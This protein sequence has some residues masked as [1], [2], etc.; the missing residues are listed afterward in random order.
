MKRWLSK[1][2][3]PL[4]A[5]LAVMMALSVLQAGGFFQP[6]YASSDLAGESD[7]SEDDSAFDVEAD[8]DVTDDTTGSDDEVS[9]GNVTEA[10]T[11]TEEGAE[12][13]TETG[14]ETGSDEKVPEDGIVPGNEN[15]D[16]SANDEVTVPCVLDIEGLTVSAVVSSDAEVPADVCLSVSKLEPD[17]EAAVEA[18]VRDKLEFGGSD[19][20]YLLS[21]DVS[22][23][24]G[25]ERV[26]PAA[27]SVELTLVF[28][29]V[30]FA[31]VSTQEARPFVFHVCA[32]GSVEKIEPEWVSETELKFSVESFSVMGLALVVPEVSDDD[33]S[34]GDSEPETDT[35]PDDGEN[36]PEDEVSG[37]DAELGD[38]PVGD[39]EPEYDTMPAADLPSVEFEDL[40]SNTLLYAGTSV[41]INEYVIVEPVQVEYEPYGL[42]DVKLRIRNVFDGSWRLVP[43]GDFWDDT[44][45]TPQ[46]TDVE[47]GPYY[48]DIEAYIP[49][50]DGGPDVDVR[51]D[52]HRVMN[53][54]IV[55][56]G[57]V[58]PELDADEAY[59]S[60]VGFGNSMHQVQE[61]LDGTSSWD[62][63][64]QPGNDSGDNNRIVRTF[65]TIQYNTYI[66]TA[67][68]GDSLAGG[69]ESGVVC[70]EYVLHDVT[71]QEVDFDT[72]QWL[73][74][75]DV[76]SFVSEI[77]SDVVLRGSFVLSGEGGQSFVGE[78]EVVI[79][80]FVKVFN[81]QNGDKI[82]FSCSYWM[83]HNDIGVELITSTYGDS[84]PHVDYNSPLVSSLSRECVRHK[85]MELC[86]ATA[87]TVTVSARPSFN[88]QV[89]PVPVN[90]AAYVGSFDFSGSV[91]DVPNLNIGTVP[92]GRLYG[93]GVTLMM[94]NL[95]EDDN[96]G[97][98][99]LEL[100]QPGS[101]ITFDLHT[102]SSFKGVDGRD[103]KTGDADY[104]WDPLYWIIGSNEDS[105]DVLYEPVSRSVPDYIL[106]EAVKA[107][108]YNSSYYSDGIKNDEYTDGG[109]WR[110]EQDPDDPTTVHVTVSGFRPYRSVFDDFFTYEDLD[111][112]QVWSESVLYKEVYPFSAGRIWLVQP[113]V[114]LSGTDMIY[115]ADTGVESISV[116]TNLYDDNFKYNEPGKAEIS[117]Q[118]KLDDDMATQAEV[119]RRPGKISDFI[120]Y[121]F[122]KRIESTWS[123][124]VVQEPGSD[125]VWAVG[126]GGY[127][128]SGD[129]DV[130]RG[131]NKSWA[132][133]GKTIGI[134]S[135]IEYTGADGRN[136]A[137]AYDH[138]MKW[139]SNFFDP[140]VLY[141]CGCDTPFVVR[142]CA[143]ADTDDGSWNG[144]AGEKNPDAAG[145]DDAMRNATPE[146]MLMYDSLDA[147][148][149]AGKVCVGVYME[150]RGVSYVSIKFPLVGGYVCQG[151]DGVY[152]TC[153]TN[154][155]WRMYDIENEA[156][157]YIGKPT[158]QLT[159]VDFN[160]YLQ[161]ASGGFPSRGN[162]VASTKS[163]SEYPSRFWEDSA[164]DAEK[165][166]GHSVDS[167][168]SKQYKKADYS[169][170]ASS[171]EYDYGHYMRY[172]GDCCLVV[173]VV[174]SV[175]LEKVWDSY[176]SQLNLSDG[177]RYVTFCANPYLVFNKPIDIGGHA[178]DV[179]NVTV[180]FALG[181]GSD[182]G[183]RFFQYVP[184]TMCVRNGDMYVSD[185]SSHLRPIEIPGSE[186][187]EVQITEDGKLRVTFDKV[188]VRIDGTYELPKIYFTLLVGTPGVIEMDVAE[189]GEEEARI[190]CS[191]GCDEDSK[192]ENREDGAWVTA[193]RRSSDGLYKS[194]ETLVVEDDEE[195]VFTMRVSNTNTMMLH[196][197]LVVDV[198]PY[199][200]EGSLSNFTGQTVITS[201]SAGGYDGTAGGENSYE[202]LLGPTSYN[203]SEVNFR[204]F[205][206]TVNA[207]PSYT[208]KA[209]DDEVYDIADR[210]SDGESFEEW[211][212]RVLNLFTTGRHGDHGGD[213]PNFTELMA[214]GA[215]STDEFDI[216][217][218]PFGLPDKATQ[219]SASGNIGDGEIVAI[220]AFGDLPA[221][222]TLSMRLGMMLPEGKSGESVVNTLYMGSE[223]ALRSEASCYIVNRE[224][225]GLAW[226][227]SNLNDIRD[228]S[229]SQISGLKVTLLKRDDDG[230]YKPVRDRSGNEIY[231]ITG[232]N[233]IGNCYNVHEEIR[234]TRPELEDGGYVFY[235][236]TAGD[237][238]VRF[239]NPD[240]Q[241]II[242]LFSVASKD[243]LS[244]GVLDETVDSDADGVYELGALQYAQVSGIDM[245]NKM[246]LTSAIFHSDHHDVGFYRLGVTLPETGGP[247]AA[248]GIVFSL[249]VC[250][251]GIALIAAARKRKVRN[252]H[253]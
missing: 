161:D 6:I 137:A 142:W 162:S 160:R 224:L 246:Y 144:S 145:Y 47:N 199:M 200:G 36:W 87:D 27:G 30:P 155:A 242:S 232:R 54:G 35:V 233:G 189:S 17:V 191:I 215:T 124:D 251:A 76:Q 61:I 82:N 112:Q 253:V 212:T 117:E 85:K 141:D 237:Y 139:D 192:V 74:G 103:R 14:T 100:P 63:D 209:S 51:L 105:T 243:A 104:Q 223:N 178:F 125:F 186:P 126:P 218:Q 106:D 157:A 136:V 221:N 116:T 77:G 18:V 169:S 93:F 140:V 187:I 184:G 239:S 179:T 97:Y 44:M 67:L 248:K 245:P 135:W 156:A 196:N 3:R 226:L 225:S 204:F 190:D 31:D 91:S 240:G 72:D 65:D 127:D 43:K 211:R 118:K 110:F 58:R 81:M 205:Y 154:Y 193:V 208:G 123:A 227:D 235:N 12:T 5:L 42:C 9:A 203:G 52:S 23:I 16:G 252:S 113:Y 108:P 37:G 188:H 66:K 55:T 214:T 207:K 62:A 40:L 90:D 238:A 13:G 11:E 164:Q 122:A 197:V 231:V 165:I 201:F 39:T 21:Y 71:R 202:K 247:G 48:I 2:Y 79:P 172:G 26:E 198:L 167:Y 60:E 185:D 168:E 99:G 130:S 166:P 153:Q 86:T 25:G 50:C 182:S 49:A 115:S 149:A 84:R 146:D 250:A 34:D 4:A 120:M 41:D 64:D 119:R 107:A 88:V 177:Q 230:E 228:S 19:S 131:S 148:K 143:Y 83:A 219:M 102:S 173:P 159:E 10:D 28:D 114:S 94:C 244:G 22:L 56:Q 69:F 147:L 180:E 171:G 138:L 210:L 8:A 32:D 150:Y 152:M 133:P 68:Q 24:S 29:E 132:L 234:S 53:V 206:V 109:V 92:E 38:T 163:Y 249:L 1:P 45:L 217:L 176:N 220:V 134:N 70:F 236:V 89:K 181:M 158:A 229:E 80:V 183:R 170:Y 175:E 129:G 121:D 241:D 213:A 7:V 98:K 33:I 95:S 111:C 151:A 15:Q 222:T 96:K 59:I 174:T 46:D 75:Y 216:K 20:V 194:A 78:S 57:G 101:T 195:M 73:N 128:T